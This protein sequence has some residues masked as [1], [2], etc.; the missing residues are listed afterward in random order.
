MSGNSGRER[1]PEKAREFL[2]VHHLSVGRGTAKVLSGLN[3]SWR[4]DEQWAILGP[5]G[6][7]KSLLVEALL[8][9]LA[10]LK[11]A[12]RGPFGE[13]GGELA[14]EEAIA[15]VSPQVQRG[16]ALSASSFYQSRWHS[17]FEDGSPTVA[18][19]LSQDSVE[20]RNPYQVG[21]EGGRPKEFQRR[22]KTV[23]QGLQLA[24]LLTRKLHHLSNGE[25][26]K[27]ILAQVLLR[28]PRLLILDDVNAGLDTGTRQK[29]KQVIESLMAGA[30]RV[31]V[32]TSRPDEIPRA[33]TH[34][35]LMDRNRVVTAGSKSRVLRLWRERFGIPGKTAAMRGYA[36]QD[37]TTGRTRPGRPLVELREVTVK[38]DGNRKILRDLTWTVRRGECW[39]LTG[40]NGAGKTTL[41]NL[42]QG[43]HPQV[44]AQDVRLFGRNA[45][46][47]RA[48][49]KARRATGWCSPELH[50]HY[51][52][53]WPVIEV[54]G[55]GFFNTLG[56]HEHLAPRQRSAALQWLQDLGL[57]RRADEPFA[58]LTFG[59]Q[60]LVLLARAAVKRPQLLILD[61]VCQGLDGAQREGVLAAA[62][63]IVART[64]ASLLFVT[65]RA[66]EIPRCI[67]HRLRIEG[68]QFV[69]Q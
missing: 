28:Q 48:V 15:L 54:V 35:L 24:R 3:W 21:G 23:I 44:Y 20:G 16:L 17:G 34:L 13:K 36:T 59:D 33:T 9:R 37:R 19:F 60:R 26:R 57:G 12:I 30:L 27:T 43:D 67:T 42:I 10:V 68:G 52:A 45:E 14:P 50:H 64:G 25:L 62:D 6:S 22:R 29:L 56:L 40:P 53:N 11:G 41:L 38:G 65:H 8:G 55:S 31:L 39:A 49:W 32:L 51:P 46:S 4:A 47:T 63:R 18:A 58:E 69:S 5:D 7:G 61:E 2:A 66:K 1:Q